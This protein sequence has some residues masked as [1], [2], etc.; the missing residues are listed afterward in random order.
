M[1]VPIQLMQIDQ[2]SCSLDYGVAPC[3]ASIGVTGSIKCF[4]T[5]GTC[6]DLPNYDNEALTLT[7]GRTSDA[8]PKDE[9][10]IP[11]L[12]S[13]SAS[14]TILNAG[15]GSR[16][17][18]P[19][20][21]RSSV[22]IMLQDHPHTDR[23]VDKYRTER[24]YIATDRGTFWGKWLARNKYYK[25]RVIRV[26]DG[27]EGD[28]IAEMQSRTYVID[29]I[30]GPDS[31]GR[32]SI[33]GKDILRLADN[34]KAQAP[35][36]SSGELVVDTN[37]TQTT[38]RIT[39]A[40]ADNYPAPGFVRI[41]DEVLSYS[42]VSAASSTEINITGCVRATNGTEAAE[43]DIEDRV[44]ICLKYDL[45]TIADMTYD[46][47]TVYGNVP[48][49]YIDK[50]AWDAE[51]DV[52]LSQFNMS[53]II[54]EP[55][56]VTDL[57]GEITEQAMF[58]IWWDERQQKINFRAIRPATE[59]EN[60]KALDDYAN[61][62]DGVSIQEKPADR[63]SQVWVY[64]NQKDTSKK[65]DEESNY[66]TIQIRANLTEEDSLHYGEQSI[67]KIFS[68][69]II[70]NGQAVNISSRLLQ[71]YIDTP[72]YMTLTVD[73][74]DRALWT[75]D[76]ADITTFGIV[77]VTGL[78]QETRWQ[79]VEADEIDSGHVLKYKLQK[80]AYEIGL[81]FGYWMSDDAP[82]FDDATD[83]EKLTGAWWS[84]DDGKNPDA[85]PG[86]AWL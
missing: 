58:Y 67:K 3:A 54:T 52:W 33:K 47:L 63:V 1:R 44:Q 26:I 68:R 4:N 7:F 56:G 19:L 13:V 78:P 46:L 85:T 70:N 86:A 9:Y 74:K 42:G 60:V 81:V 29:S 17:S 82:I 80:Y 35:F 62:M 53:G 16:D 71:Q 27:Y 12:I 38:I 2:D 64:W 45:S 11:S 34:E 55:T 10:I 77:D 32:V 5:I 24:G 84:D 22:S 30:N 28:T 41:N 83:T 65:L 48:T 21:V 79:V 51:N 18:S 25:N 73:A 57:L 49:V 14:P 8:L 69:W 59:A 66:K 61:I 6:Q 75:G 31:N 76:V 72:K 40:T 23:F 39:G 50:A 43:H 20:G 37:S 36:A 15:G